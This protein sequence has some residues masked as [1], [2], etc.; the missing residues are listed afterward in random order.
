MIAEIDV[1]A[2]RRIVLWM[3]QNPKVPV[4]VRRTGL[5]QWACCVGEANVYEYHER[6]D[7]AFKRAQWAQWRRK[8]SERR[9]EQG[10]QS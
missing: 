9:T 2:G 5:D 10:A 3:H 1:S 4:T 7:E 6:L 8:R